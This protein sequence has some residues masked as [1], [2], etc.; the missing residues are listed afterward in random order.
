[1][2]NFAAKDGAMRKMFLLLLL[3]GGCASP[4]STEFIIKHRYPSFNEFGSEYENL[5]YEKIGKDESITVYRIDR[6]NGEAKWVRV[7]EIKR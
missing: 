7:F 2:Q 4:T 1:M 6:V 3:S 5:V